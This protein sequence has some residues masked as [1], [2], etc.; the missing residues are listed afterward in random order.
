M[1]RTKLN[2]RST[3]V[4]KPQHIFIKLFFL[5]LLSPS[6]SASPCSDSLSEGA[7]DPHLSAISRDSQT[8]IKARGLKSAE[9][10]ILQQEYS[11]PIQKSRLA[12]S[13]VIMNWLAAG[14]IGIK[15]TSGFIED[16]HRAIPFLMMVLP[17]LYSVDVGTQ[18]FHKW[19]DSWADPNGRVWGEVVRGF[20]MHHEFPS[21]LNDEDYISNLTA[22][23]ITLFPFFAAVAITDLPPEIRAS[24]GLFLLMTFN[25]SEFHKQA[26]LKKP[27]KLFQFLQKIKIAVSQK[28]HMS[29]HKP[30]F[31]ENYAVFNGWFNPL[32]KFLKIWDRLDMLHWKYKKR[33]PHNW[34]QDPRSIP[35]EI[36]ELLK[37]DWK[38]VPNDM[39]HYSRAYPY[40]LPQEIGDS[41]ELA[42]EK[43]RE[44]FIS[45]R[46]EI[47]QERYNAGFENVEKMWTKEQEELDWI[48]GNEQRSLFDLED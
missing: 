21:N 18:F 30:P 43:W 41:V 47:F 35:L 5:F 36:I 9:R 13:W 1:F 7:P 40:R 45:K 14:V 27:N 34:I 48:Y 2:I 23:G 37:K 8:I 33:M 16:P 24:A 17:I 28:V 11:K 15:A 44:D 10:K 12:K 4:I 32:A 19:L 22:Y 26:H 6:L 31:D 46:R 39:I 38:A 29:H 3:K 42:K 25:T 20:R